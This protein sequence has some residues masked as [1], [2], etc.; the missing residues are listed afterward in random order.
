MP[1][2]APRG[3][4]TRCPAEHR[5]PFA[6]PRGTLVMTARQTQ[7]RPGVMALCAAVGFSAALTGCRLVAAAT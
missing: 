5:Y 1:A 4:F 3:S 6:V 7:L 2:R